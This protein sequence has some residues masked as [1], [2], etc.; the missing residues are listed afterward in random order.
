M[1]GGRKEGEFDLNSTMERMFDAVAEKRPKKQSGI[2]NQ[3][4]RIP[5]ANSPRTLS[6]WC[7][8]SH[9]VE[10]RFFLSA[11]L[12]TYHTPMIVTGGSSKMRDQTLQSASTLLVTIRT[13]V[14]SEEREDTGN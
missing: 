5:I 14:A 7:T 11:G 12:R 9:C 13:I 6:G 2:C 8:I 1:S 10:K 3:A 4:E